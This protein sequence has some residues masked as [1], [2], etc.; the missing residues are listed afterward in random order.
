M[1]TVLKHLYLT[2]FLFTHTCTY[3]SFLC[4]DSRSGTAGKNQF[5]VNAGASG[6]AAAEHH[7]FSDLQEELG[8]VEPTFQRSLMGKK[9]FVFQVL[10]TDAEPFLGRFRSRIWVQTRPFV[11]KNITYR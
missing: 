5:D 3:L 9:N 10:P 8:F 2:S 7:R 11:G 6:G 1:D 4:V